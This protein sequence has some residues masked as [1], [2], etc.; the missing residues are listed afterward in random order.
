[1]P[2]Y[3]VLATD[4]TD[5]DCLE[6][7]MNVRTAHLE[8]MKSEKSAGNF[9]TG[10]ARLDEYGNMNGSMLVIELEN[11]EIAKTWIENDPYMTGKVWDKIEVIP[12][13]LANV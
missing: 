1:M 7:R 5:E 10:G 2:Q 8:R 12:F 13:R 9:I 11:V 3:L 4:F 6:R